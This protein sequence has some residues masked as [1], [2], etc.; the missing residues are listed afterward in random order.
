MWKA[1][2]QWLRRKAVGDSETVE[3]KIKRWHRAAE[4][5]GWPLIDGI[6]DR[7][8]GRRRRRVWLESGRRAGRPVHH[9]PF[10]GL[11]L[12]VHLLPGR[13][14]HHVR[15]MGALVLPGRLLLLRHLA[16]QNRSASSRDPR[17]KSVAFSY[18]CVS[19]LVTSPVLLPAASELLEM[20]DSFND[21]L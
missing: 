5:A 3:K 4:P 2:N 19:W 16:L 10:D 18:S 13:W 15:R 11:P 20:S 17:W 8:G 7:R 6:G 21:W 1:K 12:G 14:N 9:R